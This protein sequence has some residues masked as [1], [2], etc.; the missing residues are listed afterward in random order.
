MR[1][2]IIIGLLGYIIFSLAESSEIEPNKS[3]VNLTE[4][5]VV[6]VKEETAYV[7]IYVGYSTYWS[8]IKT[9]FEKDSITSGYFID[10]EGDTIVTQIR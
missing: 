2:L 4:F 1:E 7:D 10:E 6:A 9:A 3:Q 5:E 8:E